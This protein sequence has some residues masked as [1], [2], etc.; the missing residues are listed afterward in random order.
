MKFSRLIGHHEQFTVLI[1]T[2]IG[3]CNW[4]V[5]ISI[6]ILEKL[7]LPIILLLIVMINWN[8]SWN[9]CNQN[10]INKLMGWHFQEK[11][12]SENLGIQLLHKVVAFLEASKKRS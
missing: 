10:Y 12:M 6:S 5:C 11:K 7:K 8:W 9:F 4:T 3:K 2:L 1:S